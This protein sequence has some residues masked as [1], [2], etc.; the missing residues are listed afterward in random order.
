MKKFVFTLGRM[1]RYQNQLLNK[2]KNALML[3][4]AEKNAL[5]DHIAALEQESGALAA[6]ECTLMREGTTVT[7]LKMLAIRREALRIELDQ[8]KIQLRILESSIERQR[9]VVL[10]I[11]RE[12]SGL[13][14]LEEHQLE[15]YRHLLAKE[16]E[17]VTEEFIS[18]RLTTG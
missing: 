16:A 10:G 17:Q 7:R 14:K 18:F 4:N 12:I 8:A 1:L 5:E 6:R 11:T 2:E 9:R 13:E 15:E 3:L